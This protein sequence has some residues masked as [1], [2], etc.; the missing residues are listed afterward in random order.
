MGANVLHGVSLALCLG[1]LP[2]GFGF[3][4]ESSEQVGEHFPVLDDVSHAGEEPGLE[5]WCSRSKAYV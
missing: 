1:P 5:V 4:L 3:G 2:G